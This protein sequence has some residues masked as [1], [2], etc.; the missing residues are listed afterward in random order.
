MSEIFTEKPGAP[1]LTEWER[2]AIALQAQRAEQFTAW[3]QAQVYTDPNGI[4]AEA[5]EA[6]WKDGAAH[7]VNPTA[8]DYDHAAEIM[9]LRGVLVRLADPTEMAG[10]G[11]ATEP[12]NDT[13]EMRA[14]LAYAAR[15][16]PDPAD[17]A[18]QAAPVS[19]DLSCKRCGDGRA[20]LPAS[21]AGTLVC[22]RCEGE[23]E[24]A[25]K[26]IVVTEAGGRQRRIEGDKISSGLF[27]LA[28]HQGERQVAWYPTGSYVCAREERATVPG[29][30]AAPLRR[31]LDDLRELA[32]EVLNDAS[33]SPAL[34]EWIERAQS[35]GVKGWDGDPIGASLSDAIEEQNQ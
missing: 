23:P 5:F 6:G 1:V 24:A 29:E 21:I 2:D 8:E 28:V 18:E 27:G 11:D 26:V 16:V 25:A 19:P 10:F 14:R 34:A 31:E 13:P 7:V 32:A 12:H 3:R 15:A 4:L 9:R 22:G 33:L 30:D 35:L 17:H 20:A